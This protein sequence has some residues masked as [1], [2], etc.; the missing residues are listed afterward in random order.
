[1]NKKIASVFSFQARSTFKN[2]LFKLGMD[3]GIKINK[4]FTQ[5]GLQMAIYYEIS[6]AKKTSLVVRGYHRS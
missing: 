2:I 5:V 6:E 4:L 3:N 1:L